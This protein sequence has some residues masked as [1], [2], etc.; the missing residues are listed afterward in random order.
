LLADLLIPYT[1]GEKDGYFALKT[2]V[3]GI[4]AKLAKLSFEIEVKA[5]RDIRRHD[6]I[7]PL[8]AA[9]QHRERLYLLFPLAEGGNLQ[10]LWRKFSTVPGFEEEDQN[11]ALWYNPDW[12][13]RQCLG[14]A[15]ALAVTHGF[16]IQTGSCEGP[17]YLHADIKPENILCFATEDGG[18]T[19]KLAD[20]GEA[21]QINQLTKQVNASGVAH[22][23]TYLP[24]EYEMEQR[25]SLAFDVWCLGCVYL[26]FITWALE[27]DT[28][29]QK[30]QD[31][32]EKEGDD[33]QVK[34][35]KGHRITDTFF[36]KVP[37]HR[38]A[39]VYSNMKA[40]RKQETIYDPDIP[41]QIANKR[42]TWWFQH[43][44]SVGVLIKDNV[45]LVSLLP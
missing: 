28:G 29:I 6:R 19:L 30:F 8:L 4:L 3:G 25:I 10:D 20:F 23:K 36:K 9:M 22:V 12:L 34:S 17:S 16:D 32:R 38:R 13:L 43:S 15:D 33:A 21:K 42:H 31:A 1:Q 2:F 44:I 11:F 41:K 7:V 14:I 24:P 27:G 45:K 26:E 39:F 35:A 18:Y 5:N 37:L 40:G